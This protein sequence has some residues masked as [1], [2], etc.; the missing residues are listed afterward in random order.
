MGRVL[1]SDL[2][3]EFAGLLDEQAGVVSVASATHYLGRPAV[4][5]RLASGRWQRA[6]PGVLVTQSGPMTE[7]QRL[8]APVLAAGRG[9]VLA[10]LTAARLDGL[11]GFE[12]H[13]TDVLIPA[14]RRVRQPLPGI[15]VHRSVLLE[16]VD[17][18]PTRRPPRT[19]VGRSLVDAAAWAAT[20]RRARAILAAGVQQRLIRAADLG[21]VLER[22]PRVYR[23]ALMRATLADVEGG[24]QAL[25]ELDFCDL[26]RRYG[27]PEPD[28]QFERVDEQGRRWLDAVWERARLVVE[29]DGRWHMDVRVWWADM[30]RD[31]GLTIDG[32]RV[33]RFPAFVVRDSPKTVAVQ[34][35]QAL[36]QAG[37]ASP[38][39]ALVPL[40]RA[41]S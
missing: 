18:H 40:T 24:A 36:L 13:R 21:A 14:S 34:I 17:V 32:Y 37:G 1:S 27:L 2:A 7:E 9:A 26:V 5:W 35:A 30:R 23:R 11:A 12:D 41:A 38:G 19:R 8:W 20:D 28:R 3:S 25:S 31:N 33:L 15:A 6:G 4:R 16:P 39:P 29:I 10:G 22:C